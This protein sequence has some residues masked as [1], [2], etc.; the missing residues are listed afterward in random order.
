[1]G[2]GCQPLD[3]VPLKEGVYTT[4]GRLYGTDSKLRL[5]GN[6]DPFAFD[7]TTVSG[8]DGGLSITFA[9]LLRHLSLAGNIALMCYSSSDKND[10]QSSFVGSI[11]A[12]DASLDLDGQV[13]A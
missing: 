12:S 13:Q 7:G 6:A 8:T 2:L 10:V 5:Y 9:G 3:L 11:S 1:M 4:L